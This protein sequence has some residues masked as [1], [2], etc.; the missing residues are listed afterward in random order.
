MIAMKKPALA[1]HVLLI[2]V[3]LLPATAFAAPR[4]VTGSLLDDMRQF[5][6]TIA[7]PGYEQDLS[8]VLAQ[9]LAAFSPKTDSLGN[10]I[11]TVGSGSPNRLLVAPIDEPGYVVSDITEQGYLRLQRLPQFGVLP[12]FN[13]LYSA[14]PVK[15]K[16]AQGT[17]IDGVVAGP[18]VHLQPGRQ[19]PPDL[20]DIENMYVDIGAVS[21]AQVHSAGADVLSP[22]AIDR[23][24]YQMGTSGW[25]APAIGD[26]FGA[27]ALVEVLRSLDPQK[28]HGSLTVAFVTQQWTGAHGL[29]RLLDA[30]KP[31]E[32]IYVGR[33]TPGPVP[34]GPPGLGKEVPE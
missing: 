18:S 19:H 16:D 2:A 15:I 24:L 11:V 7:V 12:L 22:L 3:L 25:T 4:R 9:R 5:V 10:V 6:R 29:Q 20:N 32:L 14:Q 13:E 23:E 17:W 1:V 21:A 30:I 27:A 26:R 34:P 28:L 33:L 31:E 8:R